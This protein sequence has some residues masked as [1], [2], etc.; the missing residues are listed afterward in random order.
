MVLDFNT[1]HF[2]L[3]EVTRKESIIPFAFHDE[4]STNHFFMAIPERVEDP[5]IT[6]EDHHLID[7]AVRHAETTPEIQAQLKYLM[8]KWPTVCTQNLG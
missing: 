8:V 4:P 2:H 1:L 6:E 5:F 7:E 3:P